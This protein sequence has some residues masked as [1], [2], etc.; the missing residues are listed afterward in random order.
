ME[1]VGADPMEYFR[2][3]PDVIDLVY[4]HFEFRDLMALTEIN[5]SYHDFVVNS[6][7]YMKKVKLVVSP[8][9]AESERNY[10]NVKVLRNQ[11]SLPSTAS[12]ILKFKSCRS[13]EIE[14]NFDLNDLLALDDV[15]G[16]KE[17]TLFSLRV[18]NG[19]FCGKAIRHSYSPVLN[20][21]TTLNFRDYSFITVNDMIKRCRNVKKLSLT[22]VKSLMYFYTLPA[23]EHLQLEELEISDYSDYNFE[24]EKAD[25]FK[26]MKSQ[27]KSLKVLSMDIWVGLPTLKVIMEMPQLIHLDLYELAK[28]HLHMTWNNLALPTSN[29][30]EH[31]Q[32]QD[33]QNNEALLECFV[34]ACPKLRKLKVNSLSENASR[35]ISSRL[36]QLEELTSEN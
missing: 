7:K 9:V 6:A 14:G 5:T 36:P 32:L 20:N 12:L 13:I 11:L 34:V 25:L 26:F 24:P 10:Q 21:V 8:E 4:Q 3:I 18:G 17:L 35:I 1:N 16:F 19:R 28:S 2:G 15:L 30:I 29:S 33:Y 22:D 27:S 23:L 31:L